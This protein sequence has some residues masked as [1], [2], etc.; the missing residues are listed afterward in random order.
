[1]LRIDGMIKWALESYRVPYMPIEPAL[2]Q[3]RV[4][5]VEFVMRHMP[6]VPAVQ[7]AVVETGAPRI[8]SLLPR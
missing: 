3:E 7:P 4:R 2:M 6:G 8:V 5:I 1:V